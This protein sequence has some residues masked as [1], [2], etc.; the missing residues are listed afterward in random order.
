MLVTRRISVARALFYI[1]A[2]LFGALL[3]SAILKLLT[4]SHLQGDLGVPRVS[5]YIT[6]GQ[7]FGIEFFITFV[8]LLAVMTSFD[9]NR[10][11]RQGS[12]PT[13]LGLGVA[14]CHFMAVCFSEIYNYRLSGTSFY[15][16]RGRGKKIMTHVLIFV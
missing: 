14:M 13:V 16:L 5:K 15:F 4:P 1:L 3:G 10:S 2:Q 11:D 8:L 7:A 12:V 9:T 6:S